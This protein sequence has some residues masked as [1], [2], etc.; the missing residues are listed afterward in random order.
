MIRIILAAVLV[1]GTPI[2]VAADEA[3]AR[4]ALAEYNRQNLAILSSPAAQPIK[5]PE[6][7]IAQRRLQ[8]QYC[9]E[10]AR[11]TVGNPA[12]TSF[13]TPFSASFSQCLADEAK[14]ED[15]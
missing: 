6:A 12:I 15:E 13:R 14:A 2:Y 8:E 9:L 1:V 10:F 3:C 7:T 11:C 5:T 4:A